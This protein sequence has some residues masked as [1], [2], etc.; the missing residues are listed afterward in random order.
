LPRRCVFEK[1]VFFVNT[2]VSS[3]FTL[4][5]SSIAALQTARQTVGDE[6]SFCTVALLKV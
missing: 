2:S 4:S 1:L 6:L 5:R 3:V